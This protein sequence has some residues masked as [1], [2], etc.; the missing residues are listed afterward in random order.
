MAK[1]EKDYDKEI[2]AI[3]K[4][5]DALDKKRNKLRREQYIKFDPEY[6]KR[7]KN[8]RAMAK[9]LA[10]ARKKFVGKWIYNDCGGYHRIASITKIT[11]P[12]TSDISEMPLGLITFEFT[13]TETIYYG[14]MVGF[15]METEEVLYAALFDEACIMS[16]S[17]V[18]RELDISLGKM[19]ADYKKAC[20][21]YR[22]KPM[23]L[24]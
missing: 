23:K 13:C 4:Q 10:K 11:T 9:L 22:H 5:I 20:K 18:M 17:E 8:R 2:G 1:T 7:Q 24:Q 21:A 14:V 16:T 3:E 12:D 6:K 19:L 15:E